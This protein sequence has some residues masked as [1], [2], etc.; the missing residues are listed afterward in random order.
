VAFANGDG[1]GKGDGRPI[2]RYTGSGAQWVT[3]EHLAERRYLRELRLDS[4]VGSSCAN[5]DE[6]LDAKRRSSRSEP[7]LT[8]RMAPPAAH[9]GAPPAPEQDGKPPATYPEEGVTP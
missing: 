7:R 2:L 1:A 9:K 3:I 8:R 6:M 4:I 5:L